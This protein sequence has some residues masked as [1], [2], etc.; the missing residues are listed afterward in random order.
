MCEISK[1]KTRSLNAYWFSLFTGDNSCPLLPWTAESFIR[2]EQ[3]GGAG[4]GGW[5]AQ[6]VPPN[7]LSS[8]P[9]TTTSAAN[10]RD[11]L[12][13]VCKVS[14]PIHFPCWARCHQDYLATTTENIPS[15]SLSLLST[16]KQQRHFH[17]K[18]GKKEEEEAA[19]DSPLS[20]L[21]DATR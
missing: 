19:D 9:S 18:T 2:M 10:S 12:S 6:M 8:F 1:W 13:R 11:G 7:P 15:L 3:R 20:A 14:F 4:R 17:S 5:M 16:P 21:F